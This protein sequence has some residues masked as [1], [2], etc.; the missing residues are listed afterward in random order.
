MS[1]YYARLFDLMRFARRK[2]VFTIAS[3]ELARAAED[4]AHNKGY[5]V[6][7]FDLA[8]EESGYPAITHRQ[9][10][11]Y[12][13][14]HFIKKTVHAGEAYGPESIFQ[15]ITQCYANRLGHGTF[16]FAEDMIQD[17]NI[18]DPSAFV[19]YLADYIAS[20]RIAIEVCPTSNL[21]TIPD[22][23]SIAHHPLKKMLEYN[24]SVCI[25]TDN[26][27]VSRTTVSDEIMKV[28]EDIAITPRQLRNLVL[29]GFKGSFYPGTYNAKRAYVRKA[30]DRYETLEQ[31]CLHE[32]A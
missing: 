20:Q 2:E 21:Q 4:L 18:Q 30:I 23:E 29:A 19:R 1:P 24:L 9:A 8:G 31:S 22:L 25:C 5:P 7:G 11:Q 16:L 17:P 3:L 27:L 28:V 13:A 15:A 12:C 10:Y 14:S 6:V 26:R 32:D